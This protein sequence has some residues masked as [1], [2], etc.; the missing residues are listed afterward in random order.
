[1]TKVDRSGSGS[2]SRSRDRGLPHPNLGA[3]HFRQQ[4]KT[5]LAPL[6]TRS[7]PKGRKSSS[8]ASRP[9]G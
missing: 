1:M 2:G 7:Y 6:P 3:A 4:Q 8:I 9:F 5:P